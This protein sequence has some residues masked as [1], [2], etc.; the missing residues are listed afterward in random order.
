M[1]DRQIRSLR[2]A[3]DSLNIAQARLFELLERM[4][5]QPTRKSLEEVVAQAL[6]DADAGIGYL[7]AARGYLRNDKT[8]RTDK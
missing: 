3:A 1:N 2:C 6:R 4:R 8:T 7:Q 5:F